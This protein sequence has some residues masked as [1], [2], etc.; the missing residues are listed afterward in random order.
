MLGFSQPT[1]YEASKCYF[2]YGRLS[3]LDPQQLPT[4]WEARG[5]PWSSVLLDGFVSRVGVSTLS[6]CTFNF[7]ADQPRRSTS[8]CP[9]TNG[10]QYKGRS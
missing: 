10:R 7:N 5:K 8:P 6:L 4:A 3:H 2:S 1:V 9:K